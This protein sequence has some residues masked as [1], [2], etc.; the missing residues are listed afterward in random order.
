MADLHN[1][2]TPQ[3]LRDLAHARRPWRKTDAI[4]GN[5]MINDFMSESEFTPRAAAAWPALLALSRTYG[6]STVPDTTRFLPPPASDAFPEQALGLHVLLDQCPRVL[7]RGAHG[8][9]TSWFDS[10]VR[11]LYGYFHALPAQQRPWARQRWADASFEYWFCVASE[12]N[13]SMAHQ[14]SRS[15]QGDSA[16][17]MGELRCA[18]EA[19]AGVRDPNG[20]DEGKWTNV[21]AFPRVVMG[22]DVDRH[23]SFHEAAFLIIE[24]HEVHKRLLIGMDGIRIGMRSR[25]GAAPRRSASGLRRRITLVR[26]VCRWRG[27]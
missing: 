22:V 24:V 17:F 12:F 27:W 3:L 4:S 19:Y 11:R 18:V 25:G 6:P 26:S 16:A 2:I 21:Y 15:H 7:F 10:V 9:W 20:D 13:A 1:L 23:W 5:A 14:E 8:R